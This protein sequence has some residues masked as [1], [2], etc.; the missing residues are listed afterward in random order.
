MME[1]RKTDVC[2][3]GKVCRYLAK[4]QFGTPGGVV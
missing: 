4:S 2:L 1:V 3:E